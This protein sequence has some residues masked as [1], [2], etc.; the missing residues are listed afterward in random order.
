MLKTKY[1]VQYQGR[2][3]DMEELVKQAKMYWKQDGH[4]LSELKTLDIYVKPEEYAAYYS[5][6]DEEQKG[7]IAF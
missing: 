3:V 1:I 2:E 7:R 5:I 4:K 6:N